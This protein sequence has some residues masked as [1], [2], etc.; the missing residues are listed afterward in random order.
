MRETG[1]AV[2]MMAQAFARHKHLHKLTTRGCVGGA[3]IC[4]AAKCGDRVIT[5]LGAG[6]QSANFPHLKMS[7]KRPTS[8]AAGSG[9]RNGEVKSQERSRLE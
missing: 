9:S 4:A 7:S 1:E 3:S 5:A 2:S 8:I 6:V